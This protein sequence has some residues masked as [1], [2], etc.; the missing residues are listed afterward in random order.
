VGGACGVRPLVVEGTGWPGEQSGIRTQRQA[1]Q[2]TG[3]VV[4]SLMDED[5]GNGFVRIMACLVSFD[6]ENN[7]FY[8]TIDTSFAR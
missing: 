6:P 4:L 7:R 3:K 8:S 2:M 5:P 1:A